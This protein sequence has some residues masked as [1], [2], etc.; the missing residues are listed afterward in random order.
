MSDAYPS[1]LDAGDRYRLRNWIVAAIVLVLAA[2][3]AVG[4]FVFLGDSSP[5]TPSHVGGSTATGESG[6]ETARQALTRQTD[7]DTCKNALQQINAE[8]S[9]KPNNPLPPLTSEQKTWL[10]D[11]LSLSSAELGEV[12]ANH[13]TLPGQSPSD[14]LLLA[15]RCGRLP[16]V[17]VR[18]KNVNAIGARE[19][20]GPGG[21]SLRL[22]DA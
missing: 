12:G 9:E 15:L 5:H 17:K 3:A 19:A 14:S 13:F 18:G 16:W 1:E 6:A 22:G 20:A 8:L 2:A 11:N 4:Y 7:F 10:L 21:A